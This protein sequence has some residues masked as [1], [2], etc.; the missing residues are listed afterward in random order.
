MNEPRQP[1][2]R[3]GDDFSWKWHLIVLACLLAAIAVAW[4]ALQPVIQA[5]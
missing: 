3:D 2:R 1:P 5:R 4:L